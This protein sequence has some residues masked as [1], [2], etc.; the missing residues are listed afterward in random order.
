MK[1]SFKVCL[2]LVTD[3]V[4]K[5]RILAIK[6][7]CLKEFRAHAVIHYSVFWSYGCLVQIPNDCVGTRFRLRVFGFSRHQSP[8]LSTRPILR[9]VTEVRTLKLDCLVKKWRNKKKHFWYIYV[10]FI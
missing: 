7:A 5:D 10:H 3:D 4:K 8:S 6:A 2:G 9:G 1:S